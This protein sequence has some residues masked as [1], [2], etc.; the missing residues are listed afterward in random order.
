MNTNTENKNNKNLII[1]IIIIVAVIIIA[2]AGV[3]IYKSLKP[4]PDTSAN[5]SLLK[6][7]MGQTLTDADLKE[8]E[9]ICKEKVGDKFISIEKRQGIE[10]VTG[11]PTKENGEELTGNVGDGIVVT[12][13]L[14]NDDEKSDIYSA[15]A[16]KFN[17]IHDFGMEYEKALYQMSFNDI[18]RADIK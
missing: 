2:V 5:V 6:S 3:I 9:N 18:N 4:P 8:I 14:L 11:F 10:P 13:K 1:A 12:F 7:N 15:I 17:F 16:I